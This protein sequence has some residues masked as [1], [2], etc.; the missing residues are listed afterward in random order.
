MKKMNPVVHFEIPVKDRKK[1]ADFYTQV[2]GW[3]AQ[4]LG[5]EMGNYV[6]VN[7][8]ESDERGLAKRPGAINGGFSPKSQNSNNCPSI[9][10]AVDDIEEYVKKLTRAGAKVLGDPVDIPTVGKFVSFRDPEG[11]VCSILQP[12]MTV[13][14]KVEVNDYGETGEI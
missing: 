14:E 12:V 1:I 10:I 2:F 6:T 8:T 4:F 5:K 9:V 7:T 3:E 11:N 13:E